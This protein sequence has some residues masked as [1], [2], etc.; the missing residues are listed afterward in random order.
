MYDVIYN[1]GSFDLQ[2]AAIEKELK[3]KIRPENAYF[4]L[5]DHDF[6]SL[7]PREELHQ[8]L[9]GTYGGYVIPSSMHL[10]K[11]VLRKPE[12][13]L[14]HANGQG[15]ITKY[16]VSNAML[17]GV[18]VR[19]RDRLSAI[20]SSTSMIEVTVEYAAHFYDMYIEGH[21]AKHLTGDRIRI[22]LLNL[23]FLFRDLIAPEVRMHICMPHKMIK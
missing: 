14:R 8:F 9:V 18:W 4:K 15:G 16:L 22:L 11:K 5:K 7:L 23:P 21:T 17:S 10:I 13:I 3:M 19:L 20:D 1:A 6:L 12:F 2:V